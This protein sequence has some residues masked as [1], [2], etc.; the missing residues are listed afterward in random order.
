[1]MTSNGHPTP[2]G[3]GGPTPPLVSRGSEEEREMKIPTA[4]SPSGGGGGGSNGP[5]HRGGGW[6][7]PPKGP[8]KGGGGGSF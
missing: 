1:M 6:R 8:Q 4:G 2:K 3:V 7:L 5:P